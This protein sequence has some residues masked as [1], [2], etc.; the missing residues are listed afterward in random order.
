MVCAD[1]R[2]FWTEKSTFIEGDALY[3]VGVASKSKTIEDG[4]EKA[5]QKGRMEVM[6]YAQIANLDGA[7][8]TIETQM[9]Y[10]ERNKDRTYNVYRLLK[11]DVKKLLNAQKKQQTTT[12]A[13]IKELDK[14]LVVNKALTAD[15][16]SKQK[17]IAML[18]QEG[19]DAVR[20][21][22]EIKND[23]IQKQQDLENLYRIIEEKI[24]NRQIT[25]KR[26]KQKRS[27]YNTQEEEIERLFQEIK[28]RVVERSK[29]A[30][31]YIIRGMK[32][33]DVKNLLGKPDG[34]EL[35]GD[36]WHYGSIS[37]FFSG[38]VVSEVI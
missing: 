12:Q 36:L 8:I 26:I 23:A 33:E 9:T 2:P 1:E 19:K 3:A 20:E 7:G 18:A 22:Q 27:E 37:I 16:V 31:K 35:L 34:V 29:K 38:G 13:R 5:F 21:L 11:T 17:E 4:R 24:S 25:I 30:K 14:M 10:E 6:N 28:N 15:Y 32:K